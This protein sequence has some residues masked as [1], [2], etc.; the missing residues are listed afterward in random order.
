MTQERNRI[1]NT[2]PNSTTR[3]NFRSFYE[4][5]DDNQI[6]SIRH[7]SSSSW[8]ANYEVEY[9]YNSRTGQQIGLDETAASGGETIVSGVDWNQAGQLIHQRFGTGDLDPVASWHYD[10]GSLRLQHD[11]FGTN[12]WLGRH[13]LTYYDFD[14]VGNI[15]TIRDAR[16]GEQWQCFEYDQVDRLT[17]AYTEDGAQCDGHTPT[18]TGDYDDGFNF[19]AGGNIT[20]RFNQGAGS[21][22]GTYTYGD[23][24]LAHAVTRIAA[25]A[26]VSTFA[27]DNNGNMTTRNLAGQPSQTLVWDEGRRLE[28]VRVGN[29]V[30]ADF[31]YAID[32]RRVRRITDGVATYYLADGTEYTIDGTDSYFTY[33]PFGEWSYGCVH[34]IGHG[35]DDVDGRRH[36]QLDIEHP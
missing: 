18:G 13:R 4:Y 2:N 29:T 5:R 12:N 11:R 25:G 26:S 7:P 17:R 21:T 32:D 16:L 22:G 27:Y 35:C 1:P 23:A 14:D 31:L 15:E 8:A 36:R 10:S 30:E 24:G 33:F 19:D 3:L 20:F 28:E 34:E 9:T 6:S